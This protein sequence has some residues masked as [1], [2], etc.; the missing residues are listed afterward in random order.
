MKWLRVHD[1]HIWIATGVVVLFIIG[2][3]GGMILSGTLSAKS[4][5]KEPIPQLS[6]VVAAS[7]DL[8]LS[9]TP[10]I[11]ISSTSPDGAE[12]GGHSRQLPPIQW[13]DPAPASP[14]TLTDQDGRETSLRG[15]LGKVVLL[16]FIFT[17]C[18]TA[19]PL[20]VEELKGLSEKL[21]RRMG[22]DVVFLSVTIDPERDTPEALRQF[23]EKSGVDFRGWS[24][25]TGRS[26]TVATVLDAYHVVVEREAGG[27]GH[28]DQISHSNPLYLIDQ[29]GRVRKRFAPT[30]LQMRGAE[31]IEVLIREGHGD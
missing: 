2:L 1:T 11:G 15:F 14:F 24:F 31:P 18:T 10:P 25:L 30:Y 29:W 4:A 7:D 8:D 5:K 16:N 27:H 9:K 26:A 21:G 22:R 23:G 12:L 6:E 20:V 3:F 19:C 17:N 13:A 28:D